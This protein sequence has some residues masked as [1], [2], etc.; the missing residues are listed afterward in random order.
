[1]YLDDSVLIVTI[2]I[3]I[4]HLTTDFVFHLQLQAISLKNQLSA[5]SSYFLQTKKVLATQLQKEALKYRANLYL[6]W[7]HTELSV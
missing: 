3:Q 5:C 4:L 2:H 6:G 7:Q 1:M